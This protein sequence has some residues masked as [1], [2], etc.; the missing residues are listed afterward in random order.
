MPIIRG[1]CRAVSS[2]NF[3][4]QTSL[5]SERSARWRCKFFFPLT[6]LQIKDL[7]RWWTNVLYRGPTQEKNYFAPG[8]NW[9][10]IA[11]LWVRRSTSR[12]RVAPCANIFFITLSINYPY[13]F[14]TVCL[15]CEPM[16]IFICSVYIIHLAYNLRLFSMHL[17]L[18]FV[19]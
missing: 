19:W 17:F 15:I 14:D 16:C 12:P 4:V 6:V 5:H 7:P 2:P 13:A 1:Y 10:R 18:L 3:Q 9:T 8:G 11:Q